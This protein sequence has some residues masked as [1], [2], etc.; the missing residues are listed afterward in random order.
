VKRKA[1][2]PTF[3]NIRELITKTGCRVDEV[4]YEEAEE[5]IHRLFAFKALYNSIRRARDH[6]NGEWDVPKEFGQLTTDQLEEL[7]GV[8][9]D[10]LNVHDFQLPWLNTLI[11]FD[12]ASG[13]QLFKGVDSYLNNRLRLARDDNA[14]Y[15]LTIHSI[16]SIS[17]L[18]KQN[19]A[20]VYVFSGLS[21][22]R[23]SIIHRQMN[24]P[25][26]WQEFRGAYQMLS[27][28]GGIGHCLVC[29]NITGEFHLE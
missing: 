4:Q 13:S 23:Q 5:Y 9:F 15:F 27:R 22:E 14:V 16:T 12:D 6:G 17:P 29:D 8:M 19:T 18:I 20:I 28:M 2:D 3:E 1:W 10:I 7:G 21:S 11:L 26:D 25:L 24:I